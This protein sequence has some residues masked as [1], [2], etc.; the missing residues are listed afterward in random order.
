MRSFPLSIF[1]KC[2]GWIIL[3]GLPLALPAKSSAHRLPVLDRMVASVNQE[4]ITESE[5]NWQLQLLLSRLNQTETTLPPLPVLRKQLLEKMILEK[6]QLQLAAEQGIEVEASTLDQALQ[7]LASREGLSIS[8]LQHSLQAQ[9]LDPEKFRDTIK[10]ELIISRL[11]QKEIAQNITVSKAEITHFLNSPAGQDHSGVEY[12]L[13]H[14]LIAFPEDPTKENIQNIEVQAENTVK[15]L[16]AGASFAKI[17]M[18]KSADQQA[19]NGGDLGWR[20]LA[21]IPT[22]FSKV[23]P[24]LQVNEIYGPIRDN[25]GF[26]IIKLLGKRKS[27]DVSQQQVKETHFRQILIKIHGKRSDKEAEA[28][29]AKLH[30]QIEKGASFA[31]LAQ[32]FSEEPNSAFKGG[33]SGW[34]TSSSLLPEFKQQINRLKPGEI[35][36]PFRTELGWHIIQVLEKRTQPVASVASQNKAADILY[37]RKFDEALLSWLRHLKSD[38]EIEIYLNES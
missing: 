9:G 14:I 28:L 37:H 7:E 15:E 6:L 16:K 33:D 22:L 11:Q 20:K 36:D 5:L 38:A 18:A 27:D 30:A 25:S 1:L 10:K 34:V 3:C 35:S 21:S 26:H 13:G 32:K 24:A 8:Q 17:A 2:F 31:K 23:V 4:A 19:L 29:L 12:H